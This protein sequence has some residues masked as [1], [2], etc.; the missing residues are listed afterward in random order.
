MEDQGRIVANAFPQDW[1]YYTL[2]FPVARY[3]NLSWSE[4]LAE[5]DDCWSGF[6]SRWRTMVRIVG[7]LLRWRSPLT[8]LVANFSYR[9]NYRGDRNSFDNLNLSNGKRMEAGRRE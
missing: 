2:S 3:Q 9:R 4:I 8:P 1:R 7:S 6:Y 5:M